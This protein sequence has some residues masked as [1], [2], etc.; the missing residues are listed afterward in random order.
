MRPTKLSS[1]VFL[2]LPPVLAHYLQAERNLW[3]DGNPRRGRVSLMN[4]SGNFVDLESM[5]VE[6]RN[7]VQML[8]LER[9]RALRYKI[10]F[11]QG[12][13]DA[14]RHFASFNENGRLALQAALV[15][16]QVQGQYIAEPVRFEFDLEA[17]TLYREVLLESCI[18]AV[19]H[20]MSFQDKEH[21]ACWS[22]AGYL[23]GHV[24]EILGRRVVTL[25]TECL[26]KEHE[27][28]RFVSKLDAEWG[29]EADWVR[30]AMTMSSMDDELKQR[31]EMVETARKAVRR[32]QD[33]LSGLNR[34]V[35]S[36]L[37]MDQLVADSDVMLPV[38]G[39]A[40]QLSA[41]D[42]HVLIAGEAGTGKSMFARS[43]HHG[44]GRAK[45][46]FVE[47][48]CAGL[49]DALLRQE[50][51]GFEQGALPGVVQPYRGALTRAHG[52]TLYLGDVAA[53]GAESQG[54]LLKAMEEG[55]VTSIGAEASVKSD[56]RVIAAIGEDPKRAVSRGALRESLYYALAIGR[57]DL[58]PL[59]ERETDII[60]LAELFLQ[61]FRERHNRPQTELSIE[62]RQVLLETAWP[63]NVRQL[64]NVIEHAV[65]MAG[66]QNL[67]PAH[68]PDEILASRWT[69]QPQELTEEVI[70]AAL[71]RCHNNRSQAA[72]LLGVGRTTLW[73]SM[74]KLNIA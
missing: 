66:D 53:M 45:K 10:G 6:R 54:I 46:P 47:V 50:L 56:F 23:A 14:N 26:C 28:C 22:M 18:E 40:R 12:R 41:S 25:E 52:G 39:R 61:E 67:A 69:R 21:C 32:M 5:A 59:R 44:G 34:R 7:L 68:L 2:E 4:R 35:R 36:E 43:I 48:D 33:S 1:N 37:L 65:I 27:K 73:R 72:D 19:T 31:D 30:A 70:R 62:F 51:L 20:K 63:G 71:N 38:A 57:I 64:R 49:T 60:R 55:K 11:E 29:G 13:R 24:S 9:A 15:F 74:K 16:G 42:A 3:V 8:G 58:P 17:R